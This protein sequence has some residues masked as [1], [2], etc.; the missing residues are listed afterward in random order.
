VMLTNVVYLNGDMNWNVQLLFQHIGS[1]RQNSGND[2][3][4]EWNI[5]WR[6]RDAALCYLRKYMYLQEH[7]IQDIVA[8]CLWAKYSMLH[9]EYHIQL[10]VSMCEQALFPWECRVHNGAC[11]TI[12]FSKYLWCV[13]WFCI[14]VKQNC[15][16]TFS[17]ERTNDWKHTKLCVSNKT[18][19]FAALDNSALREMYSLWFAT[20]S[21]TALICS[22]IALVFPFYIHEISWP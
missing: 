2:N 5:R 12:R 17:S 11:L 16:I 8:F 9:A 4:K 20:S 7:F 15:E 19:L 18:F 13:W 3:G 21:V 14:H 22:S 1:Y 10:Q 6:H